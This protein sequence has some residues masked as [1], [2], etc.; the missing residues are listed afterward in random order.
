MRRQPLSR[1]AAALALAGETQEAL[2]RELH[3]TPAAVS[4]YL[5]GRRKP[6]TRLEEALEGLVGTDVARDILGLI[7]PP[8]GTSRV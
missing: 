7:P 6:P 5:A 3:A 1:A 8:A 4:R 2:A